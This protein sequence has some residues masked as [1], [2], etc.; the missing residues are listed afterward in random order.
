MSLGYTP[1]LVMDRDTGKLCVQIS[2][3]PWTVT[4]ELP[5]RLATYSKEQLEEHLEHVVPIMIAGIEEQIEL[6]RRKQRRL[7]RK[8]RQVP[9]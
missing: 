7:D 6:E 2:I 1:K 4:Q 9:I 3:G 8:A 5:D